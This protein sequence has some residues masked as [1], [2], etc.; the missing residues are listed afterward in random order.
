MKILTIALGSK[1][2]SRITSCVILPTMTV[3]TGRLKAPTQGELQ[4]QALVFLRRRDLPL[5]SLLEQHVAFQAAALLVSEGRIGD[6][7]LYEK[8]VQKPP[9]GIT[10]S[11]DLNEDSVYDAIRALE[12]RGFLV[13]NEEL[14]GFTLLF[15]RKRGKLSRTRTSCSQKDER[16]NKCTCS[17]KGA[18]GFTRS[19]VFLKQYSA[20]MVKL[21]K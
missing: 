18:G 19:A 6:G 11:S 9:H 12:K 13:Y 15:R 8:S 4:Q 16:K 5:L 1:K 21:S 17:G 14:E 2:L 3:E 10:L 7:A 20:L